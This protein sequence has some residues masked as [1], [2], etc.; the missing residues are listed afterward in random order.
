MTASSE[1]RRPSACRQKDVGTNVGVPN[2]QSR[3]SHRV[4]GRQHPKPRFV[5]ESATSRV[6]NNL[7]ILLEKL[8]A[9]GAY[10]PGPV[11]YH[12]PLVI[13]RSG[14]AYVYRIL[15]IYQ[16]LP[17][18]PP[19]EDAVT[20]A[21][22]EILRGCGRLPVV[23][24]LEAEGAGTVIENAEYSEATRRLGFDVVRCWVRL[25]GY[26]VSARR[27]CSEIH[28]DDGGARDAR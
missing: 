9:S 26:A 13:D 11:C 22:D 27:I 16:L 10:R 20:Y 19:T 5:W 2:H 4:R 17:L 8:V 6:G 14:V 12:R 18:E 23:V 1:T 24:L 3:T 7:V 21:G 28:S 15:P 25:G